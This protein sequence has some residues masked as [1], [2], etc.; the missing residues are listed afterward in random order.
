M[1]DSA[2]GPGRNSIY[3]SSLGYSVLGVDIS[4]NA[5][6]RARRKAAGKGANIQFLQANI[7]ELSG[8]EN[9]LDTVADIGCFHSLDEHDRG[10]Y[11]AALH[12]NCRKGAVALLRAFR[13]RHRSGKRSPA[14]TG[15]DIKSAFAN[16]G[17]AVQE[18]AAL[19]I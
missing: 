3:L 13:W 8:Y 1:L 7:C 11:A 15:A 19:E 2:C 6:E 18:L 10:P 5:I 14:L 9:R 4:L 17:R 12:R 16:N